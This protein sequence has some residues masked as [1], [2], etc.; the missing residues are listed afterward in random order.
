MTNDAIYSVKSLKIATL[1][2]L[3]VE[4]L[5]EAA[6]LSYSIW[7]RFLFVIIA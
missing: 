7:M 3:F 6:L 2:Y 1:S 4:V 5:A